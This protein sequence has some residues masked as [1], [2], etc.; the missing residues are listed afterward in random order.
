M[1]TYWVLLVYAFALGLPLY[2]LWKFKPLAWFWHLVSCAAALALGLMPPP[3]GWQGPSWDLAFGGMF[4]FLMVYGVGGI[5]MQG[6]RHPRKR[7]A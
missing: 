3:A 1:S 2:L 7:H 4:L 5:V 6:S